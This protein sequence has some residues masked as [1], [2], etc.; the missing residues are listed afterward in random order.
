M[1]KGVQ[2]HDLFITG[3][4]VDFLAG[5]DFVFLCIDAD[6]HKPALVDGLERLGIAF[7]DTG[8]GVVRG[9]QGLSGVVR[10]STSTPGNRDQAR[11]HISFCSGDARNEYSTNIQVVELNAAN[12]LMAVI[13]WKKLC[14]FYRDA[15]AEHYAGFS[16]AANDI[17]NESDDDAEG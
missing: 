10:V 6:E 17:V 9:D 15:S 7:I 8:L 16:I 12:A 1:R 4:N 3:D 11:R 14:G 2:A 13:K 5:F